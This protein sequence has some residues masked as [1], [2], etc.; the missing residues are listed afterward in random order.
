MDG[1]FIMFGLVFLGEAIIK[2]ARIVK[3]LRV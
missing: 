2:A 3:G 1:A